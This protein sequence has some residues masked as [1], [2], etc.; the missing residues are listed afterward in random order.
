MRPWAGVAALLRLCFGS[1]SDREPRVKPIASARHGRRPP[2]TAL[3]AA[4]ALGLPLA[5]SAEAVAPSWPLSGERR[6]QM[7]PLKVQREA[8]RRLRRAD[9]AAGGATRTVANCDDDGPGS[10]RAEVAAAADGDRID[11]SA[12]ACSR[13]TLTSGAIEIEVDDLTLSGPGRSRLTVDGSGSQDRVLIHFGSGDLV[14]ED[15]TIANGHPISSGTRIGYGGCIASVENVVLTRSTV[16]GCTAQG[17]GSYGG[18]ILAEKL[19]MRESTLSGN[20]AFGDHPTNSTAAY[21]GGAFVYEVDILDSTIAGNQARGTHNPPLTR[22]EIGGG[23]FIAGG[24]TIERTTIENNLSYLYGGGLA[25]EDDVILRNSTV[26]GNVAR[27]GDG[28]GLR[29]RRFTSLLL[30]NSTVTDNRA[31]TAGGGISFARYARASTLRS[32]IVAGNAAP[33]AAQADLTAVEPLAIGGS[34]N[35]IRRAASLLQLPADTLDAD[36]LLQPL[37]AN[38]GYGRTHAFAMQSPLYNRGENSAGLGS[39]QRGAPWQRDVGGAPD[40]GALELQRDPTP[41]EPV[42]AL[43]VWAAA[44]L[45][46]LLAWIGR[47]RYAS[48]PR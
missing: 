27:D 2:L 47:R 41:A 33:I 3:A 15:L 32:S 25:N 22:W 42:P 7:T 23:L 20:A 28:G 44:L 19:T 21:G 10:L 5:A 40:I 34:H 31:G 8:L 11:L 4:L 29:I 37:A 43:S 12:L 17:V 24:G 39:D 48:R 38:G 18:G 14:I 46:G 1:L 13:I 45:A 35:L 6:D 9:A 30:E 26:S 36:P 16:S